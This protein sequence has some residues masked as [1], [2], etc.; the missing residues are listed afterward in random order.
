MILAYLVWHF[1]FEKVPE[2]EGW[3]EEQKV[4]FLWQKS[5]L[6]VKMTLREF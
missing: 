1:D 3:I 2:S 5:D 6:S 4:F